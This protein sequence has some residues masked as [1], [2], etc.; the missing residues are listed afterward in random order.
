MT[1]VQTRHRKPNC[2]DTSNQ[3]QTLGLFVQISTS[4]NDSLITAVIGTAVNGPRATWK[5]NRARWAESKS[6][7]LWDPLLL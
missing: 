1:S 7:S 5:V 6:L 4:A 3:D 2:K